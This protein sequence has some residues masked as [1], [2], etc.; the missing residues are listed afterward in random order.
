MTSEFQTVDD[1]LNHKGSDGYG[2][3]NLKGW[4]KNPGYMNFWLHTKQMPSA[5]WMHRLAELVVRPDK[6]NPGHFKKNIWGRRHVCWEDEAILKKQH[7]RSEGRRE[8]PP[9][10]CGICRLVEHVREMLLDGEIQDTDVLFKFEGSDNEAENTVLHAGG[11]ANVWKRDMKDEEKARLRQHGIYMGNSPNGK[12]GA[13]AENMTCKLNYVFAGVNH[14]NPGD[15]L[16]VD[17]QTQSLGDKVKKMIRNEI[18]SK[19]DDGNPFLNPYCIRFLFRAEEKKFDDKYDAL[20]IDKLKLSP[21]IEKLIRGEKPDISRFTKRFN[22]RELRAALE[23]HATDLGKQLPW[24]RIFDVPGYHNPETD[25]PKEEKPESLP[26]N[27]STTTRKTAAKDPLANSTKR[28]PE[29][30]PESTFPCDDCKTILPEPKPGKPTI[31]PKC[32]AKYDDDGESP[33]QP[34]AASSSP[35][36]FGDAVY[37]QDTSDVPF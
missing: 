4:A 13:W 32:K 19:D 3:K 6:D 25:E 33:A 36:S 10:K 24:D 20:R 17:I 14:D 21:E 28:E 37:D 26:E 22:Q 16:Q 2:L 9:Q 5:V 1:F 12:P 15:G 34:A 30:E 11:L 7:R 29:P 8:F 31:C 23:K 18:A 35:E 27:G